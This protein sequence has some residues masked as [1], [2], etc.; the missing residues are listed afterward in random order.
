MQKLNADADV[1]V[2]AT[3]DYDTGENL[4]LQLINGFCG[5]H[6]HRRLRQ[7]RPGRP[8]RSG[9]GRH[10]GRV[11]ADDRR[12]DLLRLR[13]GRL[14]RARHGRLVHGRTRTTRRSGSTTTSPA[15]SP[16]SA[17]T[18]PRSRCTRAPVRRTARSWCSSTTTRTR[19]PGCRWST[20]RS[21]WPHRRPRR[22][23]SRAAPRPVRSRRSRPPSPRRRPP[24]RSRSTTGE[25]EIGSATVE[26][27]TAT[28]TVTLGAGSH[29]LTATF[30]PDGAQFA[31]STSAAVT[32]DDRPVDLGDDVHAVPDVGPVRVADQGGHRGQGC[33]RGTDG[34]GRDP[35]PWRHHRHGDAHGDRPAR[36]GGRGDPG[37]GPRRQPPADRGL[38]RQRRRVGVAGQALVHGDE[39]GRR[40]RR[41]RRRRGPSRRAARRRS[42]SR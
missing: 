3:F 18:V 4:D 9:L 33:D 26:D 24:A 5:R 28:A 17:P 20:S 6:R 8:D 41:C 32:V 39:G 35:E 42:R 22:W 36:R 37:H 11:H 23:R 19:S 2:A 38:H 15:R 25:T 7:Q 31:G 21:R 16:R 13:R 10:P 1:T 30:T 34:H 40:R 14:G 29:S 27:G 12:L